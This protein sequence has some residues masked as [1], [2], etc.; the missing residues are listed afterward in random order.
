VKVGGV[1]RFT[2][3]EKVNGK[4]DWSHLSLG[5]VPIGSTEEPFTSTT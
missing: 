2:R 1:W 5:G 4:F 3:F